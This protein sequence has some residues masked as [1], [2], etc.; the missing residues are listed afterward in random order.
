M[1]TADEAIA[2][3]ERKIQYFQ[4]QAKNSPEKRVSAEKNIK[5]NRAII[6]VIRRQQDQLARLILTGEV[7]D[8]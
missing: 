6:D 4:S 3:L 2:A 8:P 7:T 1:M 5:L